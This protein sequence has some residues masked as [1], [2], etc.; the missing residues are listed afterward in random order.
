M[1][2]TWLIELGKAILTL[3]LNPLLYWFLLLVLIAGYRRIKKERYLFGF[4]VF[5]LFQEIKYTG[6]FSLLTG[7]FLSLLFVGLGIVF[8]YQTILLWS[9]ITILLSLHMRFSLLSPGYTLGISFLILLLLPF[10]LEFQ[11]YIDP[12]LFQQTNFIGMAIIL[13]VLLFVEGLLLRRTKRNDTFPSVVLSQRGA[14]VGQHTVKK[15]ALIPFFVLIPDGALTTYLDFW[16]YLS[17]GEESFKLVL[18]PFLLG[19]DFT[20]KGS[21]PQETAKQMAGQVILLSLF[22]LLV[23]I[24][25]I[26]LSWLSLV[27]VVLA[28]LGREY[29]NFRHRTREKEQGFYFN[30][31]EEGIKVLGVIPGTPADRLHILVGEVIKKVNDQKVN[32]ISQFYEALQQSGAFFKLEVVDNQGEVRFVQSAFYEEDHHELGLIFTDKPYRENTSEK[33]TSS[34]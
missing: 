21:L 22:V 32:D 2:E 18:V 28:I 29:I 16:P 5:D 4:K 31:L 11:S 6:I 24:G 15:L 1:I 17:L 27:A 30:K 10:L 34:L 3:F 23:S 20:V 12:Q 14:W 8:S 19:T 25:S 26:Y 33:A 7:L 13:S 9:I